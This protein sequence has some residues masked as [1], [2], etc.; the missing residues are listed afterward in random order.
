MRWLGLGGR[1]LA[2]EA[3]GVEQYHEQDEEQC[4]PVEM[5]GSKLRWG[6]RTLRVSR[7][8]TCAA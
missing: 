6:D 5:E 2:M 1:G 3:K 7:N 8:K 4:V